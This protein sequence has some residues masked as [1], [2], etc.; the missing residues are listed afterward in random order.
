[1]E[2]D[3]LLGTREVKRESHQPIN[4][5]VDHLE[6]WRKLFTKS[7]PFFPLIADQLSH[8]FTKKFSIQTPSFQPLNN[9]SN[10]H[11]GAARKFRDFG[12]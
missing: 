1:M 12:A 3:K 9:K 10:P 4:R 5:L 8:L 6:E 2:L 7:S 11:K